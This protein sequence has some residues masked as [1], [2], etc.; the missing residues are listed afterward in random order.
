[1][2]FDLFTSVLTSSFKPRPLLLYI[3]H[4]QS[5]S[6]NIFCCNC[7]CDDKVT[8]L[9][10]SQFLIWP[11]D[12]TDMERYRLY[13][14]KNDFQTLQFSKFSSLIKLLIEH[15]GNEITARIFSSPSST[16]QY[17]L[18][19]FL[20]KKEN[21]YIVLNIIDGR[22]QHADTLLTALTTIRDDFDDFVPTPS[23]ELSRIWRMPNSQLTSIPCNND[24]FQQI[25]TRLDLEQQKIANISKIENIM[26]SV[27]YS[28]AKTRLHD[29]QGSAPEE[30]EVFY[31]CPPALAHD[32]LQHGFNLR[33][34]CIHGKYNDN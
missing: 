7:L 8:D 33:N 31:G 14:R 21:Q 5:I 11:W 28:M 9:L 1:M 29:S 20:A 2:L 10:N 3:R 6:D 4:G 13:V 16:D 12:R 15:C 34:H 22:V 26:W 19:V 32:I 27:Q 30:K 23:Q 17:P 24:L 18:L 25:A